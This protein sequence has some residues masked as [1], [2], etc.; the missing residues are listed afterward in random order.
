MAESNPT[1]SEKSSCV[2]RL[3]TDVRGFI[4]Q[5]IIRLDKVD[6]ELVIPENIEELLSVTSLDSLTVSTESPNF[7]ADEKPNIVGEA[8]EPQTA[9]PADVDFLRRKLNHLLQK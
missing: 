7:K 1:A 9:G 4:S 2:I 8:V 3:L 5:G 6:P